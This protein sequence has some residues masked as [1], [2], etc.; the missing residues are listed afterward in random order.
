M[1]VP[2]RGDCP[3]IA[4]PDFWVDPSGHGPG[5]PEDDLPIQGEGPGDNKPNV[6]VT[7]GGTDWPIEPIH[8]GVDW[9]LPSR[10]S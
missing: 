1:A 3:C 4:I 5:G 7:D 2:G 6:V 9:L 8:D 10:C